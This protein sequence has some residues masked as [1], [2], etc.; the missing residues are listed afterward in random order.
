MAKKFENI[1]Y[2]IESSLVAYLWLSHLIHIELPTPENWRVFVKQSCLNVLL[3]NLPHP[4]VN[5]LAPW[6]ASVVRTEAKNVTIYQCLFELKVS[7][8]QQLKC[9]HCLMQNALFHNPSLPPC[10][11]HRMQRKL[12]ILCRPEGNPG[13]R[14]LEQNPVIFQI[15]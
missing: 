2:L 8:V 5:F 13:E 1:K 6:I 3:A 10:F 14:K 11:E 7:L 4:A 15:F 12:P 9:H